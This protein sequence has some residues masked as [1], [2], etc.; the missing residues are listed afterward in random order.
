[1]P[2]QQKDCSYLFTLILGSKCQWSGFRICLS[3]SLLFTSPWSL[4]HD[5]CHFGV[6]CPVSPH[7]RLSSISL[8]SLHPSLCSFPHVSIA[9]YLVTR[10]K[11]ANSNESWSYS[12]SVNCCISAYRLSPHFF[13]GFVFGGLLYFIAFHFNNFHFNNFQ[14]GLF[15]KREG[16][17]KSAAGSQLFG[18]QNSFH[19]FSHSS[20][21]CISFISQNFCSRFKHTTEK[22][23]AKWIFTLVA[24]IPINLPAFIDIYLFWAYQGPSSEAEV[25]LTW[26]KDCVMAVFRGWK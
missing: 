20:A 8:Q 15:L 14:K 22:T 13:V 24:G 2:P 17:L 3:Q 12:F 11:N 1:M 7:S 21:A 6:I 25:H 26:S 10:R 18:V 9:S 19:S 5:P 16:L 23:L 4:L